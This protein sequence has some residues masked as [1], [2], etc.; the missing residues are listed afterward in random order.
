MLSAQKVV[1]TLCGP[2][3]YRFLLRGDLACKFTRTLYGSEQNRGTDLQVANHQRGDDHLAVQ[4]WNLAAFPKRKNFAHRLSWCVM[5]SSLGYFLLLRKRYNRRAERT[6]I[7]KIDAAAPDFVKSLALV[8]KLD[9]D[10][11]IQCERHQSAA[12]QELKTVAEVFPVA[13]IRN[14]GYDAIWHGQKSWNGVALLARGTVPEERLRALPGA[15]DD[16]HSRYIEANVQGL[17]VGCL[18][19]PNG[20]PAPGPKF[21]Y[22]LRWLDR[23]AAHAQTLLDSGASVI[24]AGDYNIIPTDLD[25]YA[26]ERWIEDALF[27][28][29][30]RQAYR[31]LFEQGWTDAI[32]ISA[33]TRFGNTYATLLRVTRAF[34]SIT[35]SSAQVSQVG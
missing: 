23:L 33:S 13:A 12:L 9:A 22:K 16:L 4:C 20:N 11:H 30:A 35:S 2:I 26:P 31:K 32:R 28:P 7:F 17:V 10:H 29:E 8:R 34:V 1:G 21:S 19:L 3:Q 6:L 18:Y 27:H 15:P 5:Q 24:L 14:A 25:V